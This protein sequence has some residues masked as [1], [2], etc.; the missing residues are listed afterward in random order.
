MSVKIIVLGGVLLLAVLIGLMVVAAVIWPTLN[1]VKTGETPEYADLRPQQFKQPYERV[2]D[3][4][5]ATTQALGWEVTARDRDQGEIRAVA[6]TRVFR[7]K[8]DVTITIGREGEGVVVNVRSH[9]RIG[10]GDLGTN[11]RRIRQF[12]AELAKRI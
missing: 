2:F 6:T 9:S 12:Q 11:A 7:F 3:A 10:K 5:L 4:A 1:D 8:D